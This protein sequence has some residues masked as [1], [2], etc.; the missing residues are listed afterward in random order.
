M[1][2]QEWT[3]KAVTEF[4]VKLTSDLKAQLLEVLPELASFTGLEEICSGFLYRKSF[5]DSRPTKAAARAYLHDYI[6]KL[7][8]CLKANHD[9]MKTFDAASPWL[10][11]VRGYPLD[12]SIDAANAELK[13]E[14]QR[15]EAQSKDY[16]THRAITYPQQI[17]AADLTQ[18]YFETTG[19]EVTRNNPYGRRGRSSLTKIIAILDSIIGCG[20]CPSF[21]KEAV[22]ARRWPHIT[23]R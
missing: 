3:Q 14:I 7:K 20:P 22:H 21:I 11:M 10:S 6:A 19:N 17:L 1:K 15:A 8:T 4:P 16:P 2:D 13:I 9:L 5:T 12:T 18:F 23:M